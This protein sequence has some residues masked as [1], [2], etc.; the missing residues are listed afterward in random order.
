MGARIIGKN[1]GCKEKEWIRRTGNYS[2]VG[3]DYFPAGGIPTA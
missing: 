2:S 1:G 3:K